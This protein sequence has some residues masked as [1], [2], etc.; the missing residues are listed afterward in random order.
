MAI[1]AIGPTGTVDQAGF[2]KLAN[3]GDGI[4]GSAPGS[5]NLRVDRVVGQDRRVSIQPGDGAV[6]GIRAS[7]SSVV[8]YDLPA[9]ASGNARLDWI[10]LQFLWSASPATVTFTHILGTP[11][12]NPARPALVQ[13]PGVRWDLPLGLVRVDSGVGALPVN[14]V[15]DARYWDMD[16]VTA[17]PDAL[18]VLPPIQP[19]RLLYYLSPPSLLQARGTQYVTISTAVQ[20]VAV[21]AAGAWEPFSGGYDDPAADLAGDGMVSLRGLFRRTGPAFDL[22]G[23]AAGPMATLPAA[24]RPVGAR[25]AFVGASA[26]GPI[27]VDVWPGG[28]VML[29]KQDGTASFPQNGYVSLDGINYRR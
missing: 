1:T 7:S 13:T 24:A 4:V 14:A 26:V 15:Q 28:E 21:P 9:N 29:S 25:R 10:V 22:G 27:R 11:A 5:T 16:G 19:G 3:F 6:P 23:T 20:S 2:S 8:T 17:Q 18:S 12:T